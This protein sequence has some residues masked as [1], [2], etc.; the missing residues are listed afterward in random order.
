[1]TRL[2][3]KHKLAFNDVQNNV[4]VLL[5]VVLACPGLYVVM[6]VY[7]SVPRCVTSHGNIL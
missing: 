3:P 4:C 7:A 5:V 2:A 6:C 1:M